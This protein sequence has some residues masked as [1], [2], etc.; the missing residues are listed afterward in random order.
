MLQTDFCPIYTFYVR[1]YSWMETASCEHPTDYFSFAQFSYLEI[2]ACQNQNKTSSSDI[3][4]P[5]YCW[6]GET[7]HHMNSRCTHTHT[8]THEL[9]HTHTQTRS[10]WKLTGQQ[11]DQIQHFFYYHGTET[12]LRLDDSPRGADDDV[13]RFQHVWRVNLQPITGQETAAL[14]SQLDQWCK[15]KCFLFFFLDCLWQ[16]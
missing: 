1:R 12:T 13:C 14:F 16:L 11:W 15:S 10:L 7:V 9:T 3:A 6:S 5:I 4:V 8:L 2:Q